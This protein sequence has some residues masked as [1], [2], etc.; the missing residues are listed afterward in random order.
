MPTSPI[1]TSPAIS[2]WLPAFI[3]PM[4]ASPR[5]PFDSDEYLFEIKWDGTRAMLFVEAGSVRLVNRRRIDLTHRY[6]EFALFSALPDGTV[7]DGEIVVLRPDGKPDFSALQSREHAGSPRRVAQGAKSRPAT[8]VAFDQ[9]YSEHASIMDLPFTRR[10]ET[11]DHT[12]RDVTSPRIVLSRG[13]LGTGQSYFASVC[14]QGLEGM[15]AKR[16][17]SP[18]LPGK[19][20]DAWIK[21]KRHELVHCVVIGFI[22]EGTDDFGSLIIACE[23][24]GTVRCV[25]KVGTGFDQKLR[26]RIGAY[27]WSHLRKSPV[28]PCKYAGLWVEPGLYCAV[29]CMERTA[30]G[31]LR[32]PAFVELYEP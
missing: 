31:Q 14:E 1:P 10:R 26:R 8:F 12:C 2:A 30:D 11:L 3:A 29:R 20:T 28:V 13:V 7:L 17:T 24:D 22:P 6:P 18:Y 23:A 15:V 32:A 9:L 27:L 19:R 16:L 4:L 25:G 21:V 5:E